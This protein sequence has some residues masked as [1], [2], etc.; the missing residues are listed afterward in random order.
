MLIIKY[1]I[2]TWRSD[3]EQVSHKGT[4]VYI[5]ERDGFMP[6]EAQFQDNYYIADEDAPSL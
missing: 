3:Y 1:D 5:D 4:V 2:A 6:T